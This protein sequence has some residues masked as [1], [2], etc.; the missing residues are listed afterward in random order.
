MTYIS[1]WKTF[2]NFIEV[3]EIFKS[4]KYI[5]LSIQIISKLIILWI[6]NKYEKRDE[7]NSVI[8]LCQNYIFFYALKMRAAINYNYAKY[9]DI[10]AEKWYNDE[11]KLF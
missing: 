8:T 11:K 2:T 6:H 5:L 4:E 1:L 7:T 10:N 9:N 3:L